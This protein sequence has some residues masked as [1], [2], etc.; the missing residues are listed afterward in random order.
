M[1]KSLKIISIAYLIILLYLLFGRDMNF[2]G[3]QFISVNLIPFL[4]IKNY[5]SLI[6]YG[7]YQLFM[8]NVIGNIIVFIPLGYLIAKYFIKSKKKYIFFIIA[9]S[10]PCIIEITQYIFRVGILD[11]DDVILNFIGIVLGYFLSGGTKRDK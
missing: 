4:T 8:I 7:R 3:G 10:I 11:I 1:K 6:A 2:S 9:I 5:T